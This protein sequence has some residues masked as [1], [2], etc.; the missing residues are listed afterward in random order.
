MDLYASEGMWLN[1]YAKL[2]RSQKSWFM[3]GDQIVA[4]GA[5]ISSRDNRTI[6]AIAENRKMNPGAAYRI[7]L[8]K[9]ERR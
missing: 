1:G 5:G 3:C 8:G 4:L 7:T 9:R 2:A 6:E